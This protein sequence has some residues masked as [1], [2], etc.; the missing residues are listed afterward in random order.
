MFLGYTVP[1]F[2]GLDTPPNATAIAAYRFCVIN[3]LAR[4]FDPASSV[5][6]PL[7]QGHMTPPLYHDKSRRK[8]L[9]IGNPQRS[10]CRPTRGRHARRTYNL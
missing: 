9:P 10:Q 3:S 1:V 4:G 6:V 2:S 7:P 5:T 8:L